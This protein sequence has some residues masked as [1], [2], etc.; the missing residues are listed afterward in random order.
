LTS[1]ANATATTAN[2]AFTK[3]GLAVAADAVWNGGTT[4]RSQSTGIDGGDG[5]TTVANSG[6]IEANS[7]ATSLSEAWLSR[8]WRRGSDG[9]VNGRIA[10]GRHPDRVRQCDGRS[11]EYE[12]D[13]GDGQLARS[14]GIGLRQQRR[15]CGGR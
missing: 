11:Q 2:V 14:G 13:H 4:A 1:T 10:C 6:A 12:P 7:S 8:F 3:T 5:K 15:S 9:H